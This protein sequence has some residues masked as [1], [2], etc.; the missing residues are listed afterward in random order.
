VSRLDNWTVTRAE[1]ETA[2][3]G[4]L[5][6]SFVPD[7]YVKAAPHDE[8]LIGDGDLLKVYL[9]PDVGRSST[10]PVGRTLGALDRTATGGRRVALDFTPGA[11]E[12]IRALARTIAEHTDAVAT[13]SR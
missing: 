5:D 9:G 10:H 2:T 7:D 1:V 11:A 12:A 13:I 4:A 8:R 3:G 6:E